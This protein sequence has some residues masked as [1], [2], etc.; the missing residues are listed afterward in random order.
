LKA[1]QSIDPKFIQVLRKAL[2]SWGGSVPKSS[3][4]GKT[5]AC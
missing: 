4:Q 1:K 2:K 5:A 3:L